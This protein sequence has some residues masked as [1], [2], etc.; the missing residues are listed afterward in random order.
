M[1]SENDF[2]QAHTIIDLEK[3]ETVDRERVSRERWLRRKQTIMT[4]L[5]I[6]MVFLLFLILLVLLCIVDLLSSLSRYYQ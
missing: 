5:Q 4:V 1:D 3:L 2:V 6:W